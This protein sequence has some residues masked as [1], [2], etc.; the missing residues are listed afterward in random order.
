MLYCNH[1]LLE[2]K[3]LYL[4]TKKEGFVMGVFRSMIN[5]ILPANQGCHLTW[6]Q[7]HRKV[8]A[9]FIIKLARKSPDPS[10][11]IDA[12]LIDG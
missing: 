11:K 8:M 3:S 9:S 2:V 12:L 1:L 4:T 10:S 6:H 7:L 5:W